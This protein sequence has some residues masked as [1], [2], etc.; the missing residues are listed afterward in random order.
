MGSWE[1]EFGRFSDV[2]KIECYIRILTMYYSTNPNELLGD[3]FALVVRVS[4]PLFMDVLPL[5]G[6]HAHK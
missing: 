5:L 6:Q 3:L 2:A 1:Q 4:N